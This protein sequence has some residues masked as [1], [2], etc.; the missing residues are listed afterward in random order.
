MAG[1]PTTPGLV[2]QTGLAGGL[3]FLAGG[4]QTPEALADQIKKVRSTTPAISF[5]VNL[6]A[7]NPV[8]VADEVYR[9]YRDAI[10]PLAARYGVDVSSVPRTDDNDRWEDKIELLLLAPVT[11][12]SFTFGLANPAVTKALKAA[13]TLVAQTVTT[14]DEARAATENGSDVLIVQGSAAGGHS[15]TFTPHQPPTD[16]NLEKLIQA[17]DHAT[18]LPIIAAGGIARA[19]DVAAM[20]HAGAAAVMVGTALLLS[21]ECQTSPAHRRALR[22]HRDTVVTRAFTGRPARSLRNEFT[23]RFTRSAPVGYPA[24]HHL[25][26][27]LRQAAAGADDPELI[28]LWAGTGYRHASPG[29]TANI[30]AELASRL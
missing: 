22:E 20:M 1:G 13:G 15:A 12:V 14:I 3:G 24:L 6:F 16:V 5:G 21:D 23:T 8:A 10:Q 9:A 27:P 17:V 7:P 4:Y 2:V 29:P 19:T 11:V 25:T 18:Q 30:V 26:R 28:N